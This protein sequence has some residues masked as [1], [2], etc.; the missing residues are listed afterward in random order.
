MKRILPLFFVLLCI[1]TVVNAQTNLDCKNTCTVDKIVH[2]IAFLGVQFGSPCDKESKADK[3]VII[4]KVIE[5]TAAADNKLQP[6]DLVLAING[7]EVNR[8]GDA[9]NAVKAINPFDTV[10]FTVL[11]EGKTIIKSITLGAKTSKVVQEEVCCDVALSSLSEENI[12]LYPNPAVNKLNVS[13]KEV[14]QGEYNFAI[15]MTNG[16]LIK[17]YTKQLVKGEFNEEINVN[18]LDDGMYVL[19]ISKGDTTF[20]ELFVV[21]KN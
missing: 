6:Y 9:M 10:R 18:K 11:R 14:L 13:F 19:K 2:E 12:S 15:Y 21:K 16:L 4:L 20:S 7:E 17:E 8:R 1:T 3:G 5:G